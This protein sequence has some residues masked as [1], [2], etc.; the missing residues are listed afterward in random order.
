[1]V[2]LADQALE[3][4]AIDGPAADRDRVRAGHR[5]PAGARLELARGEPQNDD[6]RLLDCVFDRRCLSLAAEFLSERLRLRPV[7]RRDDNALA[8]G[9][10]TTAT[11]HHH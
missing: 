11:P 5:L 7:S 8:A 1:M 9:H 6:I 3:I 10:Q 4:V 2:I